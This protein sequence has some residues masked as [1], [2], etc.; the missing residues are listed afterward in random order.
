MN[1]VTTNDSLI[2]KLVS[3][4]VLCCVCVLL[5]KFLLARLRGSFMVDPHS[6][7][8]Y[9]SNEA[10]ATT[11]WSSPGPGSFLIILH[12]LLL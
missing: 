11:V 10:W 3:V 7:N 9:P 1:D 2:E 6:K 5:L 12:S 4:C 8:S